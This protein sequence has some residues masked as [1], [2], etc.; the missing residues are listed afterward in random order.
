MRRI[1]VNFGLGL[2]SNYKSDLV[3]RKIPKKATINFLKIITRQHVKAHTSLFLNPADQPPKRTEIRQ[4]RACASG[5]AA[6][7][8]HPACPYLKSP[9]LP[10]LLSFLLF[11]HRENHPTAR[12]PRPP[13]TRFGLRGG[14]G[15]RFSRLAS[16]I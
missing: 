6:I 11:H 2:L 13:D 3:F 8:H 10:A 12:G 15:P 1:Y 14:P 4:R 16:I 9:F 7:I 5:L